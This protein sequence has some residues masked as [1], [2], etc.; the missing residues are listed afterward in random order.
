MKSSIAAGS[1]AERWIGLEATRGGLVLGVAPST[2]WLRHWGLDDNLAGAR[3]FCELL[4]P[5][6]GQVAAVKAQMPFFERFGAPGLDLAAWFFGECRQ[7]ETLAVADAKRCDAD[8]TMDAYA[9]L[10]FNQVTGLGADAVTVLPFMGTGSVESLCRTAAAGGQ[11]VMLLVRTSNHQADTQSA[12][13]ADGRTVSE[14]TADHISALND[15]LA[16]KGDAGPV[17]ALIGAPPAEALRLA[18]RLPR[19]IVSLPGLGRP[20]RRIE[21]CA[22]LVK[23]LGS[24]AM[25]PVTTGVLAAGPQALTEVVHSWQ[26]Q[27][28]LLR[29]AHTRER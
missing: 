10:Y 12:R 24:R 23:E 28:R 25:F 3:A 1:F 21:D 2:K 9:D 11:A 26:E 6:V 20:G 16:P 13:M 22:D 17:A 7:R 14:V 29:Q 19:S 27:L 4:L 15:E 8:D 5:T 18:Q